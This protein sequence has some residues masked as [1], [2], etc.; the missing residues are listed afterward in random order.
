MSTRPSILDLTLAV[1]SLALTPASAVGQEVEGRP[2][3]A[4]DGPDRSHAQPPPDAL[5]GPGERSRAGRHRW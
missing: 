1:G 4:C 5:I 2:L 3:R